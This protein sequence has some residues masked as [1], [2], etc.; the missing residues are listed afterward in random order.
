VETDGR[1]MCEVLVGLGEVDLVGVEELSGDRLRV[2]IRSRGP[3]PV[4][5]EC[6]GRVWSKGDRLVRL[7]D[8]P[9]FGRPVRLGVAETPLDVPQ[10][11]VRGGVVRGTG[12]VGGAG[13]GPVDLSRRSLGHRAGGSP[14]AHGVGGGR[15][16]GV[17]LAYGEPRDRPVR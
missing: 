13:T 12:P 14:G 8:L 17:R 9:A 5:G 16:V 10:T 1:R 15:G 2:T 3:R 7:V 6:G 11:D 4:C